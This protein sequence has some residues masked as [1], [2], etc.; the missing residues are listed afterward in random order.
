MRRRAGWHGKGGW[1]GL[2]T[3]WQQCWE[4]DPERAGHG[5]QQLIALELAAF[6]AV[7]CHGCSEQQLGHRNGYWP[8]TLSTLVRGLALQ[9]PRQRASRFLPTFLEQRYGMI[10]RHSTLLSLRSGHF[11]LRILRY[12]RGCG[13]QQS[14]AFLNASL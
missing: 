9:I 8:R 12:I 13:H 10:A 11:K 5:L 4:A 7:D 6:L 1:A 2:A 14:I 3:R